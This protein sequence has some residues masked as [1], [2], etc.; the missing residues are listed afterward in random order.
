MELQ[1]LCVLSSLLLS[2]DGF[3]HINTLTNFSCV[4]ALEFDTNVY[5]VRRGFLSQMGK[6]FVTEQEKTTTIS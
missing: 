5:N 6:N 2:F 4:F 1:R 3:T